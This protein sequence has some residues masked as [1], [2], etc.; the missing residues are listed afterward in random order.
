MTQRILETK[1]YEGLRAETLKGMVNQNLATDLS[2][3]TADAK[4]KLQFE[5][6]SMTAVLF[7]KGWDL[8]TDWDTM[9]HTWRAR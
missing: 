8:V 9:T 4:A 5:T 6:E 1:A 7:D 3:L 2:T